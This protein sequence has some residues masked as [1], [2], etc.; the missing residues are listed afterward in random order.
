M[1]IVYDWCDE[2]FFESN[3]TILMNI[4]DFIYGLVFS[5]WIWFQLMKTLWFHICYKQQHISLAEIVMA[6][7]NK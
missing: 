6:L 1:F 5:V 2:I 3:P 7:I 4:S